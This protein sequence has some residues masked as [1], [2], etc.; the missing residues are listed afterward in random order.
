MYEDEHRRRSKEVHQ[1]GQMYLQPTVRTPTGGGGHGAHG[2]A[3]HASAMYMKAHPQMLMQGTFAHLIMD[4]ELC[5]AGIIK[6]I[7][8]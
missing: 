1:T 8:V 4:I 6:Y 5:T 7:I 3:P 2:H